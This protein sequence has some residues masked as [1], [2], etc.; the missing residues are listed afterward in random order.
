MKQESFHN[1][2]KITSKKNEYNF[3]QTEYPK[4]YYLYDNNSIAPYYLIPVQNRL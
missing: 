4:P 1:L 2:Q 3:I